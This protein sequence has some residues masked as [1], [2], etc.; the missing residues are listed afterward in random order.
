MHFTDPDH[1]YINLTFYNDSNLISSS[2]TQF[3][4]AA[5]QQ[6][7]DRS[8]LEKPDDWNVTIARFAIS[9]NFLSRVYQQTLGN[10]VMTAVTGGNTTFYVGLEYLGVYYDSPIILRPTLLPNGQTLNVADNIFDFIDII[11]TAWAS[12]S[13]AL[14]MAGGPTGQTG[15]QVL[16]TYDTT[17]GLYDVNVPAFMGTG[18]FGQTAGNGVAVTMSYELYHR[19]LGFS[20]I[21]NMPI[22]YNNHDVT[23][24][25]QW[26]GNNLTSI[27][28]PVNNSGTGSTG[29]YMVLRQD[30]EWP[31]SIMDVTRLLILSNSLPIVNEYRADQ[32]YSSF[33][34]NPANQTISMLTDFLIGEDNDLIGKAEGLLYTPTLYRLVSLKGNQPL[35]LVDIQVYV[36]TTY[37]FIFP[38]F[39]GPLDSIDIKLAFIRK[40]LTS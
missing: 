13:V 15:Q 23:F 40:G 27:T 35:K 38:L 18:T 21:E 2:T 10:N 22:Q 26:R 39:L 19:F 8:Y 17:T 31:S 29:N 6:T 28:Y 12:S 14:T 3:V 33:F 7:F 30:R 20:V 32:L 16:M 4:P 34:G 11:N 5:A 36:A 9:S 24:V 1:S 25:R 37:G